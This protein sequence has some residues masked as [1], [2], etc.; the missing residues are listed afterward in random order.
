LVFVLIQRNLQARSLAL[1]LSVMKYMFYNFNRC[2]TVHFDKYEIFL[3]QQLH[4]LL[5]HK[6][7]QFVFKCLNVH[8]SA[9]TCFGPLGPSS[10]SINQNIAKVTKITVFFKYHLKY[11]VKIVVVWCIKMSAC[12]VCSDCCV[13]CICWTRKISYVLQI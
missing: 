7:L 9:P 4:Y 13:A 12:G 10:R 3:V 1:T 8:F 5:K 2:S 11:L 6:I